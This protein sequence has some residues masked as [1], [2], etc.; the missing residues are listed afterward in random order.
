MFNLLMKIILVII[1]MI[2]FIKEF[3]DRAFAALKN[4]ISNSDMSVMERRTYEA[5]LKDKEKLVNDYISTLQA[6]VKNKNAQ[7]GNKNSQVNNKNSQNDVKNSMFIDDNGI[8]EFLN[9][10]REDKIKEKKANYKN[11]S[12][13]LIRNKEELDEFVSEAKNNNKKEI[14]ALMGKVSNEFADK[15]Y[16]DTNR[17]FDVKGYYWEIIGNQI[18]HSFKYHESDKLAGDLPMSKDQLVDAIMN[19]ESGVVVRVKNKKDAY[20]RIDIAVASDDGVIV[21]SDIVGDTSGTLQI[22]HAMR[23]SAEKV[24]QTYKKVGKIGEVLNKVRYTQG[25]PLKAPVKANSFNESVTSS[26]TFDNSKKSLNVDNEGNTL[27]EGQKEY[28]KDAKT[29]D[30]NGNLKVLYHGTGRIHMGDIV[31]FKAYKNKKEK[32]EYRKYF[33]TSK[34]YYFIL[35]ILFIAGLVIINFF[36]EYAKVT[37][38]CL[39]IG[40]NILVFLLINSNKLY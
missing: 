31:K 18:R 16:N 9:Y 32:T 23:H 19:I 40:V 33:S 36:K 35:I 14:I 20:R 7:N 6:A 21:L 34:N 4:M 8:E 5:N 29:V 15:I 37:V 28:F 2:N 22:K 13:E 26:D 3:F 12:I 11:G 39:L 10:G 25:E 17:L 30:E 24:A 38:T 1:K 27:S